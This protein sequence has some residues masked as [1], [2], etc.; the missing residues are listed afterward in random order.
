LS[1]T[2]AFVLAFVQGLTEFL[3]ISSSAHLILLPR[4]AGWA[5]QGLAFDVAVHLGTLAAVLWFFHDEVL[6][7]LRAWFAALVR[8]EHDYDDAR[9][10]SAILVATLPVVVAGFA[11]EDFVESQLRSPLVI[12]ATTALFGVLLWLADLHKKELADERALGIRTALLIGLAQALA[13]IPGTSRSGITITAGLA[14][15]LSRTAAARF[16]FLLAMPAIAGAALLE[17]VELAGA[18]EPVDWGP[19][20]AGLGVAAASAYACIRAFLGVIDRVGMLPF[21]IYRLLLAGFLWW[22]FW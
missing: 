20:L 11:F 1:F 17:T 3:P 15:G 16:S 4:L 12:A 13:L 21:M 9:L 8:R 2:E 7:I 22:V 19:L 10:G 18:P 6:A 5:D 14:L